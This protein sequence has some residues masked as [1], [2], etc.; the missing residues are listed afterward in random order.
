ME[1]GRLDAGVV[2]DLRSFRRGLT[3]VGLVA[4]FGA[5]LIW[6]G[7]T[8]QTEPGSA[9]TGWRIAAGVALPLVVGYALLAA[10]VQ[11]LPKPRLANPRTVVHFVGAVAW[12]SALW[13]LMSVAMGDK[14]S[15]SA[16]GAVAFGV[17]METVQTLLTARRARLTA[18]AE[19][20]STRG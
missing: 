9:S 6:F 14:V 2:E 17:V 4:P 10:L 20:G 1:E 11:R 8:S 5:T 7:V 13:F 3:I 18:D 15:R 19:P 16:M 12:W